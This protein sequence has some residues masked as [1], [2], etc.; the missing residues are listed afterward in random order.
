M[1]GYVWYSYGSDTSGPKLAEAL[2]FKA[3]KK[4]PPFA[5]FDLIIGWGCKPGEKYNSGVLADKIGKREI[6]VLNHMDVVEESRNK[7]L[8]LQKL[9]DAGVSTPGFAFRTEDGISLLAKTLTAL[10]E[11]DLDFPLLGLNEFHKGYPTFCYTVDDVVRAAGKRAKGIPKINYFRSFCPG[12]EFKIHVFRDTALAAEKKVLAGDP[13]KK[14]GEHLLKK[15]QRRAK[16]EEVQIQATEKEIG[17]IT[18][19]LAQELLTGPNHMQRSV[20]HGWT[21]EEVPLGEVQGEALGQAI[22]AID[23]SG[24][25]MGAATVVVDDGIVRV[26]GV[27]SAPGLSEEQMGLYV[28]AIQ[29]FAK[30]EKPKRNAAKVGTKEEEAPTELIARL[31]RL[32]PGLSRK[33]AREVLKTLEE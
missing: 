7:L 21:L 25:D 29:E 24:L 18:E 2:K 11:G 1:S 19:E 9:R 17:W 31:K 5:D 4:T 30:A 22:N 13:L 26:T 27:I 16:K 10:E 28:S 8:T 15:V 12:T 14:F 23:A 20:T 6:R 32:M 3:G 33:K